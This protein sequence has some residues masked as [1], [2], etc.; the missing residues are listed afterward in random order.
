M[1]SY[2][3]HNDIKSFFSISLSYDLSQALEDASSLEKALAVQSVLMPA[4]GAMAEVSR[5][6]AIQ[7]DTC[8]KQIELLKLR[9]G[10]LSL[11][12][13]VLSLVLEFA[14]VPRPRTP[15]RRAQSHC[16]HSQRCS[17]ACSGLLPFQAIDNIITVLMG[18]SLL[19]YA[20]RR[21][22]LVFRSLRAQRRD[23]FLHSDLSQVGFATD[24]HQNRSQTQHSGVGSLLTAHAEVTGSFR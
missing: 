22:F 11:P 19:L 8:K 5:W 12:D 10:F 2:R 23:T 3:S 24:H 21:S 20:S 14:G 15:S 4:Q 6:V 1:C 17:K 7:S 9:H 13:E 18:Q 16:A